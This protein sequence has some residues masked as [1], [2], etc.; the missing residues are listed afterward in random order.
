MT[1]FRMNF[2]CKSRRLSHFGAFKEMPLYAFKTRGM[3]HDLTHQQ[4]PLLYV[5][6]TIETTRK[7]KVV[8]LKNE[9]ATAQSAVRCNVLRHGVRNSTAKE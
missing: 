6:S 5:A 7:H 4:V 3:K 9:G 1:I 2:A 8:N